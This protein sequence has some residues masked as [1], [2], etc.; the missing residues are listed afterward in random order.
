MKNIPYGY[1]WLDR[2]DIKAV[3][4]TL[5]CKNITQGPKVKEFEDA[6][7]QYT[8]AR[9]AVCVS[10]GTAALH[11]ARLVAGIKPSDEVITSPITFAAS[12]NCIVYCGGS[13]VFADV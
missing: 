7:C 4:D 6:L 1:H 5:K 2:A 9:Y 3:V 12:A 13:P 11:I 8:G 10:C